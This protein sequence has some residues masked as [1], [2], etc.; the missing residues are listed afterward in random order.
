MLN[1][2]YIGH[3]GFHCTEGRRHQFLPLL[4]PK[5]RAYTISK[6]ASRPA[7]DTDNY[8]D[9]TGVYIHQGDIPSFTSRVGIRWYSDQDDNTTAY[10]ATNWWHTN[11]DNSV[12]FNNT[13]VETNSLSD[14]FEVKVGIQSPSTY[15]LQ[16]W[17]EGGTTM[18]ANR[19]QDYGA[20]IGLSYRW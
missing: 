14:L 16:L 20:S 13:R 19:Y 17:F 7:F 11:G 2:R 8:R 15:S 18:G 4:D 9:A 5:C 1:A 12:Y 6:S 3:H 10:L